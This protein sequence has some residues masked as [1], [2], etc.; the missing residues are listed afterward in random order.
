V[1]DR[2]V[3][4]IFVMLAAARLLGEVF[5][6]LGQPAVVGELLAGSLFMRMLF[7][8]GKGSTG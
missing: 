7:A 5:I 2:I 4:D 3:L 8:R 6:R 1:N